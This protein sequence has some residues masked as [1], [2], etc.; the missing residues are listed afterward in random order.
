MTRFSTIS[1]GPREY[2]PAVVELLSPQLVRIVLV[3]SSACIWILN[4]S[5]EGPEGIKIDPKQQAENST[6]NNKHI[7]NLKQNVS[8]F[9]TIEVF[10]HFFA[11]SCQNFWQK[12]FGNFFERTKAAK[13]LWSYHHY[14]AASSPI[15]HPSLSQEQDCLRCQRTQNNALGNCFKQKYA[16][17]QAKNKVLANIS[18]KKTLCKTSVV[19]WWITQTGQTFGA[20]DF[21]DPILQ[22]IS[23][24]VSYNLIFLS[25]LKFLWNLPTQQKANFLR[26]RWAHVSTPG[27]SGFS[28]ST[29]SGDPTVDATYS[30]K[31]AFGFPKCV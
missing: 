28:L 3:K 26:T 19:D 14:R 12:R 27:N 4:R 25:I 30:D 22:R 8:L 5:W 29:A 2:F 9:Q 7:I 24:L 11:A 16:N 31:C 10:C 18:L 21:E 20:K 1:R 17:I 23:I 6:W 15:D 13:H